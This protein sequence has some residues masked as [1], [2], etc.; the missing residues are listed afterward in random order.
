MLWL[1]RCRPLQDIRSRK[2]TPQ[3]IHNRAG[4]EQLQA[5]GQQCRL[6]LFYRLFLGF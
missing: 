2:S 5:R 6:S 4:L 1:L 3:S